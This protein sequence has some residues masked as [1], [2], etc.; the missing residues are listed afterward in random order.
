MK[1]VRL[2][3]LLYGEE[4]DVDL[5][6]YGSCPLCGEGYVYD[7]SAHTLGCTRWRGTGLGCQFVIR[8]DAGSARWTEQDIAALL[9]GAAGSTL[10]SFPQSPPAAVSSAGRPRTAGSLAL[11]R[12]ES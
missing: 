5:L 10:E 2:K 7:T 12:V 4:V 8:R 6:V 3:S 9:E 1:I 11:V